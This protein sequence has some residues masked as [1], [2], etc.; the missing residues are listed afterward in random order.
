MRKN[1]PTLC[2]V[3]SVCV[4]MSA[5]KKDTEGSNR[6]SEKKKFTT[7]LMQ[8]NVSIGNSKRSI[9]SQQKK[10]YNIEFC[11]SLDFESSNFCCCFSFGWVFQLLS[12]FK[13]NSMHRLGKSCHSV[14]TY[15]HNIHVWVC[16]L[17]Q[18]CI[19]LLYLIARI[20]SSLESIIGFFVYLMHAFASGIS[21]ICRANVEI[22]QCHS[23]CSPKRSNANNSAA[24]AAAKCGN[25]IVIRAQT[26]F[27]S[28]HTLQNVH[29]EYSA[30]VKLLLKSHPS[31]SI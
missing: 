12:H 2:G 3:K 18:I 20:L 19:S 21:T 5:M 23:F 15:P 10:I 27:D 11:L 14:H 25:N 26:R 30:A 16:F 31:Q 13:W 17:L 6:K 9:H 29:T 4:R 8:C 28:T 22:V 24:A 1:S 7:A